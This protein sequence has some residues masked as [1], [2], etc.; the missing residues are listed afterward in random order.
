MSAAV[1][2]WQDAVAVGL[3]VLGFTVAWWLHRRL[4]KPSGCARCPLQGDE[5]KF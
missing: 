4:K 5:K 2:G 1:I 3:A